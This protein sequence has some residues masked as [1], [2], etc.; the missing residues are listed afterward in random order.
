MAGE[1]GVELVGTMRRR[2]VV[3]FSDV[4]VK[5]AFGLPDDVDVIDAQF[6]RMSGT[7]EL[8]LT[9]TNPGLRECREGEV[10]R[11]VD[12]ETLR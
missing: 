12:P 5:R 4:T 7:L 6:D 2:V 3:R 1:P 10:P 9:G 11:C 8:L